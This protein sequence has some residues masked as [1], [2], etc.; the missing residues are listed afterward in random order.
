MQ[1]Y[2]YIIDNYSYINSNRGEWGNMDQWVI[3]T[4]SWLVKNI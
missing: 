4:T 1:I 2:T 3:W